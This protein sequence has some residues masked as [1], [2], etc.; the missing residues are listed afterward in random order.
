MAAR[1]LRA[2]ARRRVVHVPALG[3]RVASVLAEVMPRIPN[4]NLATLVNRRRA[5]VG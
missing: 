5:L 4:R 2:A 1:A 3:Y